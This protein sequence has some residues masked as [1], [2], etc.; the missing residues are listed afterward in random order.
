MLPHPTQKIK[1]K[2]QNVEIPLLSLSSGPPK[3]GT[4]SHVYFEKDERN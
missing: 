2:Q 3:K 1:K 4:E